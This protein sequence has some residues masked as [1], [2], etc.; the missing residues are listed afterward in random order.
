VLGHVFIE[1]GF[2]ISRDK[3]RKSDA[4]RIWSESM[5]TVDLAAPFAGPDLI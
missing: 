3:V 1:A 2:E 4:V 5:R